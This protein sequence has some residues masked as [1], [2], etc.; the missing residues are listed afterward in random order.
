MHVCLRH[1]ESTPL[2][3]RI[4]RQASVRKQQLASGASSSSRQA[5]SQ[6]QRAEGS[7]FQKRPLSVSGGLSSLTRPAPALDRPAAPCPCALGFPLSAYTLHPCL[8][9]WVLARPPAFTAT[10]FIPT[11]YIYCVCGG[12]LWWSVWCFVCWSVVS[13]VR[14]EIS[15]IW[16]L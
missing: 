13:V 8:L 6:A 11:G 10:P 15:G 9:F 16:Y 1:V 12:C 5:A 7:C 3:K 2:R 4:L 14:S